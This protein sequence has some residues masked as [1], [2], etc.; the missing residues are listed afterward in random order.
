MATSATAGSAVNPQVPVANLGNLYCNGMSLTWLT[1]TTMTVGIGQCRDSTDTVDIIMGG[2]QYASTSNPAG[3]QGLNNPV[4]A[5]SVVTINTAL[6]GAGGVDLGGGTAIT[7]SRI[8]AVFAIGD[9]RGFNAGSAL[10]SLAPLTTT[11]TASAAPAPSLPLG[12]DVYRYIG[13]VAMDGSKNLRQF[14]QT[15][16]GLLRKMYYDVPTAPGSAATGGTSTLTTIGV[17]SALVP[18]RQLD[19]LV[20]ASIT[21]SGVGGAIGDALVLAPFGASASGIYDEMSAISTSE[22][23]IETLVCPCALNGG[24]PNIVEVDYATSGGAAGVGDV[25]AFK[26]QGYIDQL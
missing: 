22:P 10:L 14:V 8:Y 11:A 9:S 24:T 17:L 21:A 23:N 12:Y 4:S 5:S 16:A 19:V 6:T 13:S 2:N 7:A 25:V 3:E 15:G 26:I 20:N 1:T 18:Q